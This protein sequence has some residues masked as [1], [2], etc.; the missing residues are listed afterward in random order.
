MPGLRDAT[1]EATL[2]VPFL[3]KVIARLPEALRPKPTRHSFV[4]G[5]DADGKVRYNLQDPAGRY[6]PITSVEE[7]GG[8]LYLGSIIEPCLGRIARPTP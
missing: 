6:A 2:P 3:R 7:H 4:L 5:I 1:L 8:T